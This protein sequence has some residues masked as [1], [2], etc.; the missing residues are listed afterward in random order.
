MRFSITQKSK[1][2]QSCKDRSCKISRSMLHNLKQ[3][4]RNVFFAIIGRRACA[5]NSAGETGKA[6]MPFIRESDPLQRDLPHKMYLRSQSTGKV[7]ITVIVA[8]DFCL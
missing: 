3:V 2:H 6:K 4:L 5:S 1:S 7:S 8:F